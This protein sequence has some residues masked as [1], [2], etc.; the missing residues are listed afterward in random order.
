MAVKAFRNLIKHTRMLWESGD[1]PVCSNS[2]LKKSSTFFWAEN[3]RASNSFN[4]IWVLCSLGRGPDS[5]TSRN[6]MKYSTARGRRISDERRRD[7]SPTLIPELYNNRYDDAAPLA[8]RSMNPGL[9]TD[10]TSR[11]RS[12]SI[13]AALAILCNSA[14][15]PLKIVNSPSEKG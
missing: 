3:G 10:W 14:E 11:P 13:S 6:L 9:V 5:R 7:P 15:G 2:S 4:N 1:L 8:R 12:N